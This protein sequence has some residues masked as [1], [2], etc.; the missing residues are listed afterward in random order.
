MPIEQNGSQSQV[1][2]NTPNEPQVGT[3]ETPQAGDQNTQPTLTLEQALDALKKA[4]AEAASHRVKL[5][6]YEDKARRDAEAQM[7]EAERYKSRASDL[8]RQVSD[9]T[10]SH[11]ERAVKYEVQLHA[12]KL[13]IIDPDAAVKLLDLS[14]LDYDDDGTPKNAGKLLADLIK[15]KPYLA[16]TPAS[17]S[18]ANPARNTSNTTTFTESQISSMTADE[19]QKNRRAIMAAMKEGRILPG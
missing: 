12:A 14:Q 9:L 19:Y 6:E 1:D 4:R 2:A 17:G 10:R 5:N 15:A 13:G 8:E 16:G 7:T 18:V 3:P 11:Q